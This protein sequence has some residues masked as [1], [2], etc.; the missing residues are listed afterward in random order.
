[1]KGWKGIDRAVLRDAGVTARGGLVRVPY[2]RRGGGEHNAKLFPAVQRRDRPKSWWEMSGQAL[3]PFGLEALPRDSYATGRVLFLAEGESDA[4]ALR[5][6]YGGPPSHVDVLGLPG[7]RAWDATWSVFASPYPVVYILGDGDQAGRDMA[8]DVL[9]DVPWARPVLLPD[10]EDVR[11]LLQSGRVSALEEA[12]RAA[13]ELAAIRAAWTLA[14]NLDD[15][16]ALLR[17][18]EVA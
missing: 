2:R 5:A 10:G 18:E 9:C 15:C 11:G 3:I 12:F 7:A 8:A 14:R 4:L 1:M 6:A 17:G 13:D 16:E